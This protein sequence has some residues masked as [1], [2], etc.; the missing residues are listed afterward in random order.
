MQRKEVRI[1]LG[2]VG[3]LL[4]I[5]AAALVWRVAFPGTAKDD[6]VAVAPDAAKKKEAS[7]KNAAQPAEREP[8]TPTVLTATKSNGAAVPKPQVHDTASHEGLSWQGSYGG[9]A[10]AGEPA[11]GAAVE[12]SQDAAAPDDSFAGYSGQAGDA[13]G[14]ADDSPYVYGPD[15]QS[16]R[17]AATAADGH[18]A[19]GAEPEDRA[20]APPARGSRNQLRGGA[21]AAGGNPLRGQAA[22]APSPNHVASERAHAAEPL[23]PDL[24]EQP[25]SGTPTPMAQAERDPLGDGGWSYSPAPNENESVSAAAQEP[26][27]AR[28]PH[29][30]DV[31][32]FTAAE[33]AAKTAQP[34]RLDGASA[35]APKHAVAPGPVRGADVVTASAEAE[36]SAAEP[37]A[38]AAAAAPP[39]GTYRVAARDTYWRI[40][41]SVYGDSA[42]Y[43]ALY[44][45]NRKQHP[46]ADRLAAGTLL[47][48]PD[49]ATLERLYPQYC[50]TGGPH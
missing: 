41:R 37:A 13:F 24:S 47:E 36:S 33:P 8:E 45:H 6:A 2:V 1:A 30:P 25:H 11:E 10:P 43:R 14:A 23:A 9:G 26:D 50:P 46:R 28:P 38:V 5:F 21:A 7:G 4:A 15:S 20:A 17:G 22:Q 42:Y 31:D 35:P 44:E 18:A 32:A 27:A 34:R 19:V 39:E 49:L 29:Q 16:G 40:A 12:A 48:T 3:V